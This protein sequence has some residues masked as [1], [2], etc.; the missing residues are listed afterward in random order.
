MGFLLKCNLFFF[1]HND[2]LKNIILNLN[3]Y[4]N[5]NLFSDDVYKCYYMKYLHYKEDIFISDY[6]S[7][8]KHMVGYYDA[9]F[10]SKIYDFWLNYWSKERQAQRKKTLKE[11]VLSGE[12]K[13]KSKWR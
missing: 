1:Y 10:T 6:K 4:V 13:M 7:V 5:L 3:N 11:F 8:V 2:K 9:L 12:Y